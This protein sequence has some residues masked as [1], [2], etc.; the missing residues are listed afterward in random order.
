MVRIIISILLFISFTSEAQMP[1]FYGHNVANIDLTNC[2]LYLDA[3]DLRS[4]TSGSTWYDLTTNDNDVTLYNSPTLISDGGGSMS[5]DGTNDYSE[6]TVLSHS[7]ETYS[8]ELWVKV[9]SVPSTWFILYNGD[10][11][12]NG[13]GLLLSNGGCGSGYEFNILYGGNFCD[14]VNSN[15]TPTVNTWYHIVYSTELLGN[16]QL[17]VNGVVEATRVARSPTTGTGTFNIAG[18]NGSPC[19][20]DVSIV[21]YYNRAMHATEAMNNYNAEKYRF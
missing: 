8:F 13:S 12:A 15:F 3:G 4:Y 18:T 10:G 19:P 20:L 9:R 17:I 6:R 21:R 1:M 5:F 7:A 2:I 16:S 14:N 11:G